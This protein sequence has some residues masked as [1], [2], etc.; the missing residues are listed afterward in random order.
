M[1]TLGPWIVPVEALVRYYLAAYRYRNQRLLDRIGMALV[2]ATRD[3]L[4]ALRQLR[5]KVRANP[6]GPYQPLEKLERDFYRIRD[7]ADALV[8]HI[9]RL[10]SK[11]RK[12]SARESQAAKNLVR[13]AKEAALNLKTAAEGRVV[14]SER[15]GTEHDVTRWLPDDET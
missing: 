13:A 12:I 1:K 9:T 2:R 10:R 15:Y 11:R 6:V 3:L 7:A 8:A 5:R 4:W 14:W